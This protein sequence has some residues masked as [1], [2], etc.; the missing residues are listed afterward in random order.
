MG[1]MD[2]CTTLLH[3]SSDLPAETSSDFRNIETGSCKSP[4][5]FLLGILIFLFDPSLSHCMTL[6]SF[7]LDSEIKTRL[8]TVV[9]CCKREVGALH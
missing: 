1:W 9:G 8:Y 7:S 4:R 3:T 2:R 6:S 5:D